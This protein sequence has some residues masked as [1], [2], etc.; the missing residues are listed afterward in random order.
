M[1][2]VPAQR[3]SCKN[4]DSVENHAGSGDAARSCRFGTWWS[5]EALPEVYD[6]VH[7]LIAAGARPAHS[8]H[9]EAS[10]IGFRSRNAAISRATGDGSCSC[11]R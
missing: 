2:V 4:P 10:R 7:V 6:D 3:D 11:R 5:V 8:S 1:Q 9:H